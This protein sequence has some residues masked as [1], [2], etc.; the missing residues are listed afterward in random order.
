MGTKSKIFWLLLAIIII[1]SFLR[2]YK[3]TTVPPGLY[4][5]EA[6]D[7]NNATEALHTGQFKVFYPENNG[8]EGLFM[9]VQAVFLKFFGVNEPWVLR[10][11]SAIYGILTVL[12]IY[13]LATELFGSVSVGLLSAF[14]LATNFW[15][16]NFS[17]ISF[18]AIM[19]PLILVWA[20]YLLIKTFRAQKPLLYVMCSIFAGILYGL[21]FYTYIAYRDTPLLVLFILI[22]FWQ[23]SKSEGWQKKFYLLSSLFLL[24][25]FLTALPIGVY[26]LH[27][28]ADF[29]GRTSQISIFSSPTPLK[30]LGVNILKTA[31][32][33]NIHGDWNWRHN[34]SGA[35]ELF[36][37][38]GIIF[39]LGLFLGLKQIYR[40]IQHRIRNA[41]QVTI[42]ENKH[43]DRR[44][45]NFSKLFQESDFGYWTTFGWLF[46]AALPVVI[47]NEALPH[48]LRS[49]LMIPP[50]IM[51]AAAGG[52][53]LY[54]KLA[55]MYKEGTKMRM[56]V[57][58]CVCFFFALLILEAY[59]SYF[60]V[61]AKNPNVYDAFSSNYVEIGR[62]INALPPDAPKYII[63]EAGGVLVHGIPMPAETVMFIT[64]TYLPQDQ[65][66]KNVHY[67]L[68]QDEKDIPADALKFYIK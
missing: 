30:D 22:Y 3:I 27:N 48:A 55:A 66:A 64:N 45:I 1:A 50:V 67:V 58:C 26:F 44:D 4:P 54:N 25:A 57:K 39:L 53:W 60:I 65:Q 43:A 24:L 23:K 10:L 61:W 15:H 37:P 34:I 14:L 11:P 52:I 47:S 59:N 13:F 6:M 40:A 18:R 17:R 68:P 38:V 2:L 5:D 41:K 9:N 7:G 51:L 16:I 36:W 31:G 20:V 12:G 63:V 33:F 32:M 21:G 35:P 49:I 46:L 8:R 19:A 42:L 29:L 62:E 56:V 28:P